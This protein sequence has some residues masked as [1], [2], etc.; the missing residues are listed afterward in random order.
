MYLQHN[1]A[2]KLPCKQLCKVFRTSVLQDLRERTICAV[3]ITSMGNILHSDLSTRTQRKHG[4]VR[5][6]EPRPRARASCHLGCSHFASDIRRKLTFKIHPRTAPQ[7]KRLIQLKAGCAF[8][9]PNLYRAEW[10]AMLAQNCALKCSLLNIFAL[11]QSQSQRDATRP[12]FADRSLSMLDICTMEFL[13]E[14]FSA[15]VTRDGALAPEASL[16]DTAWSRV[17]CKSEAQ[18]VQVH[19]RF[20]ESAQ[21]CRGYEAPCGPS[22]STAQNGRDCHSFFGARC[23]PSYRVKHPT[24]KSIF[25]DF[26]LLQGKVTHNY[27][28]WAW[29]TLTLYY[30][31]FENG[32]SL[33]PHVSWGHKEQ[34]HCS[35]VQPAF[36][37]NR[38]ASWP[39][40]SRGFHTTFAPDWRSPKHSRTHRSRNTCAR[41]DLPH[42]NT[43][44]FLVPQSAL[45]LTHIDPILINPSLLIGVPG[46]SG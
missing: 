46:F 1:Y 5:T 26:Q 39:S 29:V 36:G 35:N 4:P 34:V 2:R 12:K 21:S 30:Q 8:D 17:I 13:C 43:W 38:L 40:S 42:S 32:G 15:R 41:I 31:S 16:R 9:V 3:S 33:D 37:T 20:L 27:S 24:T 18:R 14:G 45:M 28:K 23:A 7:Q 6:L 11:H 10:R 22:R 19:H 44:P 25:Q